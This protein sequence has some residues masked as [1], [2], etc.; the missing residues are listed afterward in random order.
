[1]S[2]L[3][4][5]VTAR[6][7]QADSHILDYILGV[8]DGGSEEFISSDCIYDAVGDMLME[9]SGDDGSEHGIRK[10]CEELFRILRPSEKS[11]SINGESDTSAVN[12]NLV[13]K[14]EAPVHLA[15]AAAVAA[16]GDDNGQDMSSIWYGL[17]G[18]NGLGKTTL[19]RMLSNRQVVIPGHISILHVEQEVAGDDTT[20]LDSVLECDERRTALLAEE[21]MLVAKLAALSV[22]TASNGDEQQPPAVDQNDALGKSIGG[23]GDPVLN[24]RLNA[25]YGELEEMEADKAPARAGSILAGLGFPP[26]AQTRPTKSFSGGWRMRLALARALFA[27]PDLLLLDEPTNMLD[28][29]AIIWLE[30]YLITSWQSTILVVSHDRHFLDTVPTDIL[31]LHSRRIDCYKGDY[32]TFVR[33]RSDRLR[34]QQKEYEAQMQARAHAQ[35]FIDKFR[36]NAKRASLVQSKIKM[37]ERMP[38]LV[39]VEKESEVALKFPDDACVGLSPP[40]L[41]LDEVSFAYEGTGRTIFSG[42]NLNGTMQSRIC[43]VG[44]NGA[45]KTTLLKIILG[46][47]SPTLGMRTAHRNLKFGYFA[48]HHVDQLDLNVSCLRLAENRF[49]GR[50]QEEYRRLLGSFGLS[51]DLALQQV[52]CLSGGQ[53]SR[54]AFSLLAASCPNFLILDEP[55]NH[56]DIETI[57]ALGK[58]LLTFAGGVLLV[59]HDERL[60]RM[61]CNELWVCGNGTVRSLEGG[62]DEYR[63]LVEKAIQQQ[64]APSSGGSGSSN[65][66]NASSSGGNNGTVGGSAIANQKP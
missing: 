40:I 52:A 4:S 23:Q 19:L 20:A 57:E 27:C 34:N 43:I 22:N 14:L 3:A 44:D 38:V 31:H 26:D 36:F 59:S 28:M 49:P 7:P 55:T 2:N 56:L 62:F 51:G 46:E 13:R 24:A 15:T 47:Y 17:V 66:N 11:E 42:V 53:K 16:E 63:R 10:I 18:R 41:Q 9:V 39:P 29:K 1:M 5:I 60:V 25:V 64:Q 37:L 35:E 58:C 54:L 50:P 65:N 12:K 6:F 30:N 21:K 33:T 8:L 61:I 45:G 32:S 48:Q